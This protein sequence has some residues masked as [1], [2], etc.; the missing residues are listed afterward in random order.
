MSW[1]ANR[2]KTAALRD[3]ISIIRPGEVKPEM[4]NVDI[5]RITTHGDL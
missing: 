3:D 2:L 4:F 5:K 1:S